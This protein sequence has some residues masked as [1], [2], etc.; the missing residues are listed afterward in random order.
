M[1]G[2]KKMK[3]IK[4]QSE[5]LQVIDL[6]PTVKHFKF[7]CPKDFSFIPGQFLT[8]ILSN[9]QLTIR[10]S[11]S[12]ASST[13]K[14]YIELCIKKVDKGPAT[15]ILFNLNTGDKIDFMGPLGMFVVKNKDKK[16]VLIS[17]GTGI[18]PFRSIIHDNPNSKIML[19]TGYR[20][21]D[22]VLY[23]DELNKLR[24]NHFEYHYC[25]SQP[26]NHDRNK[27]RVQ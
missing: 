27:V 8:A 21:E 17:T 4:F 6:T 23:D 11:Y 15:N 24:N 5:L 3:P 22:E 7:S 10:R 16:I 12:L 26:I 14:D 19:L 1:V 20:S 25:I 2:L 13:D 9:G 18:G